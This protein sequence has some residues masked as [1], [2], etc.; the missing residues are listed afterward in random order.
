MT[1]IDLGLMANFKYDQLYWQLIVDQR[2]ETFFLP[3]DIFANFMSS[4]LVP[5]DGKFW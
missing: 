2:S 4:L 3:E 1:N 5:T